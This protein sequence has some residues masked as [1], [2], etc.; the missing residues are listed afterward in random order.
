M[1]VRDALAQALGYE[2]SATSGPPILDML[3]PK[4]E[5]ALRAAY[6]RGAHDERPLHIRVLGSRYTEQNGVAV[7]IEKLSEESP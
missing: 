4:I 2:P 7:G 5:E 6:V 1:N 3:A